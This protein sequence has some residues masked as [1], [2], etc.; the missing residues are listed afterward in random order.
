MLT[1]MNSNN[2]LKVQLEQLHKEIALIQNE[3][4]QAV[5]AVDD[6]SEKALK[7]LEDTGS[8]DALLVASIMYSTTRKRRLLG[9]LQNKTVEWET[10]WKAKLPT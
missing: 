5:A 8:L 1:T 9:E 4:D 10:L 6:A 3:Y 7:K 2:E